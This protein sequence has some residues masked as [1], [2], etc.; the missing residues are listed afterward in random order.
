MP[1]MGRR[2]PI[3]ICSMT[4]MPT[5]TKRA[6]VVLEWFVGAQTFFLFALHVGGG[7]LG[8]VFPRKRGFPIAA[9]AFAPHQ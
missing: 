8:R 4:D 2:N 3:E 1:K 6:F 5:V 7:T 9:F